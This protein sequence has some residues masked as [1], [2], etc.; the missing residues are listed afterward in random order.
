MFQA[1]PRE[2]DVSEKIQNIIRRASREDVPVNQGVHNNTHDVM[3]IKMLTLETLL[4]NEDIIKALHHPVYSLEEH[5]NKDLFRYTSIFPFL[6]VPLDKADVKNFLCFEVNSY[7]SGKLM[8]NQLVI[9][10][11]SHTDDIETDW[12]IPRT[13]LIDMII[14]EEID[15]TTRFGATLEKV[16]DVAGVFA[17]GYL[18]RDLV[19]E[20]VSSNN[21][22]R[23]VNG[24]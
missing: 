21:G 2:P 19:Y 9:R 20:L 7:G 24:G 10:I 14:S 23:L 15:W 18:Y 13:D 3:R 4:S 6:N 22:Y 1:K 17:S 11:I 12:G 8:K 16:Q 5:P